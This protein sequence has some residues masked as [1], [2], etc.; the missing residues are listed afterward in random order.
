MTR[1]SIVAGRFYPADKKGIEGFLSGAEIS[2]N[3]KS[4]ALAVI[5]PHAGYIYSGAVSA[6]V[7]SGVRIADTVVILGPNHACSGSPFALYG[8]GRW[9]TPLGDIAVDEVLSLAIRQA[10][11]LITDDK[12]A[13]LREHSVEVQLPI[14]QYFRR[15]LKIV[16]I[17]LHGGD[18]S[19]Y[20]QIAEAIVSAKKKT[21]RDILLVAS[22]DMTHYEPYDIVV[23]KDNIAIEAILKLDESL[24]YESVCRYNI[25]MCGCAGIIIAVSAAK[26]MGAGSARLIRYATSGDIT[27]DYES[28]VGYA[29]IIM[30]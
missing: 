14:L 21:G 12:T 7:F 25:S 24:L 15:D 2:F 9:H 8:S 22:S 6:Q 26:K 19:Q 16:P 5:S 17:I 13:H 27:G 1:Q 20:Q 10:C 11:G 28:V 3:R 23:K 18:V 30:E 29:G 4:A